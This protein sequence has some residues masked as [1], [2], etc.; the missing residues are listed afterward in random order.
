[1]YSDGNRDVTAVRVWPF[2]AFR[3]QERFVALGLAVVV[4]GIEFAQVAINVRLSYFN[5]DWYDE[6]SPITLI[7]NCRTPTLLLHGEFDPG[8]PLGQAHEFYTGLKDAGVEAELVIYPRERHSIQEYA[9]RVDLQ[10][11]VL[12]WFDKHL[13]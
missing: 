9:H 6:H 7:K 13:K 3:V 1:M 2:G 8:V 4:V 5:R 12:A 10:R 11:R